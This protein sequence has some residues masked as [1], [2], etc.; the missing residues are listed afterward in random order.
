MFFWPGWTDPRCAALIFCKKVPVNFQGGETTGKNSNT[1][2]K[3]KNWEK[4]R[5]IT[6]L[7]PVFRP[8]RGWVR[9]VC[10]EIFQECNFMLKLHSCRISSWHILTRL[11]PGRNTR[12]YSVILRN[13]FNFYN[14]GPYLPFKLDLCFVHL[15]TKCQSGPPR[16]FGVFC[17]LSVCKDNF[18][19]NFF[20]DH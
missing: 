4:F 11:I 12:H 15:P 17:F 20:S 13:F 2:W 14:F 8:W 10:N 18:S 1:V 9:M 6:E 7:Q 5:K 16:P 3:F 19:L